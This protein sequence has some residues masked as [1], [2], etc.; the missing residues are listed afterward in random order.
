VQERLPALFQQ[1]CEPEVARRISNCAA[2]VTSG[3]GADRVAQT[4]T[5]LGRVH[6]DR[7]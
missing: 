5:E 3:D 2:A 4:L 6:D 1:L 7:A